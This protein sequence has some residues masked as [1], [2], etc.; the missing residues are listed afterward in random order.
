MK[1]S[2]TFLMM[3]MLFLCFFGNFKAS[4]SDQGH[5]AQTLAQVEESEDD[6][7]EMMIILLLGG[8]W[9]F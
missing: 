5:E 2:L 8:G 7:T 6:S 4:A 9:L 1:K 3:F